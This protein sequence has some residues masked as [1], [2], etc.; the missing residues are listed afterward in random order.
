MLQVIVSDLPWY[1]A[2]YGLRSYLLPFPVAFVMGANLDREDLQ[3]FAR[4]VLWLTLPLTALQVAQYYAPAESLLNKGAFFGSGQIGSSGG[5]VRASAT[6]SFVSGPI[7]YLP[8]AAGFV[9]Y[10]IVNRNFIRPRVLVW[11]ASAAL[12]IAIPATGSRTVVYEMAALPVLCLVA[13]FSGVSEIKGMLKVTIALLIIAA[14][15]TQ[16]PVFSD[17]MDTLGRR[18]SA[19]SSAEGDTQSVMRSHAVVPILDSID[20]ALSGSDWLGQGI[21]YGSNLAAHSIL[22]SV[23]QFLAG[24]YEWPR[25]ITEF[26]PLFGISF[27]LFR[28][29]IALSLAS[30]AMGQIRE[31]QPLAWFLMVA[32]LP[33]LI[34]EIL[35]QPTIQGFVVV[36]ISFALAAL[37]RENGEPQL[38]VE[39][40][41][42]VQLS[43]FG[44]GAS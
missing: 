31:H 23:G 20:K 35:E 39:D 21:G 37:N 30:R 3:K 44:A 25:V 13:A 32:T 22:G 40:D 14:I 8:L 12:L 7:H 19:A 34:F 1:I 43:R 26:G 9:L 36:S 42:P 6:F 4:C 28:L 29:V 41:L 24:E 16:L 17:S 33:G 10:G 18:F 27:M 11:L 2:L 15:V 38:V 5:H